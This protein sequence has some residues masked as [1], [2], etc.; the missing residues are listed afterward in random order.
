MGR[1]RYLR[2]MFDWI[3]VDTD[4]EPNEITKERPRLVPWAFIY[5]T[6]RINA[7]C[8]IIVKYR[9][10]NQYTTV[11]RR[12]LGLSCTVCPSCGRQY[13]SRSRGGCPPYHRLY[14]DE[15]SGVWP[16]H[17]HRLCER[18]HWFCRE[19]AYN[20][21]EARGDWLDPS[22]CARRRDARDHGQRPVPQDTSIRRWFATSWQIWHGH[23]MCRLN[24][25]CRQ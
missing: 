21:G 23:V 9:N 4:R 14:E 15:R 8:Y 10:Q 24:A 13:G 2:T 11:R 16:Y 6:R 5:S 17:Q 19:E 7:L 12:Q 25:C 18:P 20:S 1:M 22:G 3:R